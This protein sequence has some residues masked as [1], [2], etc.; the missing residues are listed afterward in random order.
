[1]IPLS[2]TRGG[3][4]AQAFAHPR[5]L[6]FGSSVNS[7]SLTLVT[8]VFYIYADFGAHPLRQGGSFGCRQLASLT[9]S[10]EFFAVPAE[11]ELS[12]NRREVP[13]DGVSPTR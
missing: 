2:G 1:V 3:A 13:A 7:H 12:P 11:P 4:N 6:S 10:V 5:R 8:L 9:R